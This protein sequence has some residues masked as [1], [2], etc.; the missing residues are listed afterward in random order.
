DAPAS[1]NGAPDFAEQ[2]PRRTPLAREDVG[3]QTPPD[4]ADPGEAHPPDAEGPLVHGWVG[5][6]ETRPAEEVVDRRACLLSRAGLAL[7]LSTHAQVQPGAQRCLE[8]CRDAV[9]H[10][11]VAIVVCSEQGVQ[12]IPHAVARGEGIEAR[13]LPITAQAEP[14]ARGV[15]QGGETAGDPIV[16]EPVPN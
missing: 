2:P 5:R 4:R 13:N 11:I 7:H 10:G 9:S 12:R 8:P 3:C 6:E 14:A 1:A 16:A 15:P